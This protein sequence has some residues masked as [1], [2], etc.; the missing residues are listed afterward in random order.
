MKNV[1]ATVLVLLSTTVGALAGPDR[2]C[3][4]REYSNEHL[5]KHPDQM[6]KRIRIGMQKF[7]EIEYR[8]IVAVEVRAVPYPL[9]GVGVC[10]VSPDR[11]SLACVSGEDNGFMMVREN[12]TQTALLRLAPPAGSGQMRLMTPNDE[13]WMLNAGLDDKAFRL[14]PNKDCPVPGN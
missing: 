7:S 13:E 5:A 12:K 14:S 6:V 9:Y 1:I 8:Y 2:V 11:G 10:I 3:L 4:G